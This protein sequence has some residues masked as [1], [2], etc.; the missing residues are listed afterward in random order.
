MCYLQAARGRN[1]RKAKSSLKNAALR[2]DYPKVEPHGALGRERNPGRDHH[3][4]SLAH[5]CLHKV[6]Q[7]SLQR[8][9]DPVGCKLRLHMVHR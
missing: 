7:E 1:L 9:V 6:A 2:V 8:A 4:R 5:K 3:I